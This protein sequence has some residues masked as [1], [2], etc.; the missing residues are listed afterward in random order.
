MA[1]TN[2]IARLVGANT[3]AQGPNAIPSIVPTVTSA[4][5]VLNQQGNAAALTIAQGSLI[6]AATAQPSFGTN[7]DGFLFK[8]RLMG[9]ITTGASVNLTVA[10][11]VGNTT[12][13]TAGNL[14]ATTGA[15]AVNT[16]SGNFLLECDC[17]W[18][19]IAQKI[20][21]RLNPSFISANTLV[22]GALLT[23]NPAVTTQAGLVF[24]PVLTTSATTGVTISISEFTG[25]T[26]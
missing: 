1:N 17:L 25:S 8:L 23:N 15:L 26:L 13:Y 16:T 7:F 2:T 10:I 12:T 6:S 5:V 14:V 4:F 20:Y 9:K 11:M 22:S 24:V 3:P 21:G 18:D 19:S